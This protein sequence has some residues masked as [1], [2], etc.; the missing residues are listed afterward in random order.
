MRSKLAYLLQNERY[1]FVPPL[2]STLEKSIDI[3]V[4]DFYHLMIINKRSSNV[5]NLKVPVL[6]VAHF[7][8]P[9]SIRS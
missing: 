9:G 6:Y 4:F 1:P 5:T 2:Q 3:S 7:R 8:Y